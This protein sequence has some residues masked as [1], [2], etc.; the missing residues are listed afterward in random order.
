M[1][2]ITIDHDNGMVL[3]GRA[4]E[5]SKYELSISFKDFG[6]RIAILNKK[7]VKQLRKALKRGNTGKTLDNNS[8]PGD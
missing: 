3:S 7:E 5:D 4:R 6:T 1:K 8:L 2:N